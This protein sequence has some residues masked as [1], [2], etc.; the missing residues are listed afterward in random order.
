MTHSLR[1][2]ST[3]RLVLAEVMVLQNFGHTVVGV[4]S[5]FTLRSLPSS[6]SS[7]L[8]IRSEVYIRARLFDPTCLAALSC[9]SH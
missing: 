6:A 5:S 9:F 3:D 4:R 8:K 2:V 1:R 7:L